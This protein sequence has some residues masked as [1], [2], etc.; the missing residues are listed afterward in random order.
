M[1]HLYDLRLELPST[2]IRLL[3]HR[4]QL[5]SIAATL[6]FA[7]IT[8]DASQTQADNAQNTDQN[9]LRVISYNVQFLPDPVS[10]KNERPNPEYRAKRIADEIR[11]FDLAGL[12][13]VF[14]VG[15]RD[16]LVAHTRANWNGELYELTSP[17]PESF[18]TSGGCLLLSRR[19]LIASSSVVFKNFSKPADYGQRADGY[20]AKGVLHARIARSAEE[21]KNYIDVFVTHLEARADD[22][23]PLQYK[24]LAAFIKK[25]SDDSQPMLLLGD[26]NTYGMPEQQKDPTSQYSALMRELNASRPNGG[27]IDLWPQL[28]GDALGGTTEQESIEIGKRIDYI[29][30]GNPKSAKMQLTPKRIAVE[31]YQDERVGALSDHNAVVADFDWPSHTQNE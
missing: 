16:R 11:N 25:T 27:V 19:P 30:L 6:V 17:Q 7:C 20:A 21:P 1:A 15:H 5:G 26:L 28:M 23:R 2:T 24:E 12:Q 10:W 14:H 13:E 8:I 3:Q 22:L 4:R 29:V 9:V 18:F 31:L